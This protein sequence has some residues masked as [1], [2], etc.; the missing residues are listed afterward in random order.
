MT[1]SMQQ[2]L[3]EYLQQEGIATPLDE[4]WI[5]PQTQRVS[6]LCLVEREH[7]LLLIQR[8]K[9]PF[10]GL[11]TAPGGKVQEQE[12]PEQ[13]VIRELQEETG[14]RLVRPRLRLIAVETGPT[15]YYNWLCFMFH[16]AETQGSLLAGDE[17]ELRWVARADVAKIKRPDIDVLLFDKMLNTNLRWIARVQF[18]EHGA[19]DQLQMTVID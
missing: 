12:H 11:W 10:L 6:A 19:V 2:T 15:R 14:L 16:C 17:G 13:A 18:A 3:S 7:K 9:E 4:L 1:K 5:Q 8:I